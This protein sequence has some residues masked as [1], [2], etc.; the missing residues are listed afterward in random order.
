M[1]THRP[2]NAK[3]PTDVA[4]LEL[5]LE[6]VLA[7]CEESKRPAFLPQSSTTSQKGQA[8]LV[9]MAHVA[10]PSTASNRAAFDDE[11]EHRGAEHENRGTE[12]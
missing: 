10:I 9:S 1:S 3:K 12:Q 2:G 8:S 4:T 6:L 5:E 11:Y 7:S